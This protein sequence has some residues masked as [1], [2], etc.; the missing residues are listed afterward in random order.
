MPIT[1]KTNSAL[2]HCIAAISNSSKIRDELNEVDSLMSLRIIIQSIDSS[3]TGAAIISLEQATRP[4]KNLVGSGVV[5]NEIPW[6][7]LSCT[8][9]P[10]VLQLICK[11]ANFAIWVESC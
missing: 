4:P 5:F 10:L 3:L 2:S 8:G 9:G 7:L 1:A 11:K 6:R